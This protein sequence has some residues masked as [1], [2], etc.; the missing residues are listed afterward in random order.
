MGRGVGGFVPVNAN[1]RAPGDLDLA[2]IKTASLAV[3]SAVALTTAT[4]KTIISLQVPPGDYEV[5]GV[6]DYLP[7]ASTSITQ[8]S[9]GAS[10]VTN[11]FGADDTF[12]SA[13]V[14][15]VVPGA[16]AQRRAIPPQ[17]ISVL[18]DTVIFLIAQATFTV[19]TMT[20]FG[21]VRA[22]RL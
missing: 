19:S 22:K 11:T 21:T 9:E 18:V 4:P 17:R 15:A 20:A 3:G 12:S 2:E 6:V 13:S 16:V 5:D 10:V 14:A 8:M 1:V 7:A